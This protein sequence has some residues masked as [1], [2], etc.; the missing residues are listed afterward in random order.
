MAR[1][2]PPIEITPTLLLRAYAAGIFPMSEGADDP[3]IYWVEPRLRGI[4]EP[5]DFHLPRRLARTVRSGRYEVTADHDFDAVIAGCA[6]ARDGRETT[7]INRTIRELY[8]ALFGAGY[9]H[10]IECRLAGELVGGLFGVSLGRVFFGESMFSTASDAS[11]V[12]LV[13][14]VARLKAGGYLLLDT[15]F[16]TAH[17]QQF[18]TI[19][20]PR[21]DY[22]ER[23]AEALAATANFYALPATIDGATALGLIT[24]NGENQSSG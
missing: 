8:G 23:L 2:R 19:E 21:A 12:A 3:E 14:L 16:L 9:C 11:K 1:R 13:H 18:G 5:D 4:I 17:L 10:T 15:Q 22:L 6:A 24:R 7:W 20:I